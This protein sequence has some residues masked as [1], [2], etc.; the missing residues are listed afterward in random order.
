MFIALILWG[1]IA[2][3]VTRNDYFIDRFGLY[4]DWRVALALVAIGFIAA[5]FWIQGHRLYAISKGYSALTGLA[6]GFLILCG[7]LILLILPSRRK[8]LA[9]PPAASAPETGEQA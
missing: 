5:V 9:A 2:L 7:L 6:L 1:A 3:F 4:M 8:T